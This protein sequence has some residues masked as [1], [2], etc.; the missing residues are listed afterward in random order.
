MIANGAHP[1][2]HLLQPRSRRQQRGER[3][4]EKVDEVRDADRGPAPTRRRRRRVLL[5]D[6]A[7]ELNRN[8]ANA[9]LKLLEEPPA[10]LLL[11]L[12]MPGPGATAARRSARAVPGSGCRRCRGRCVEA[13]ARARRTPGSPSRPAAVLAAAGRRQSAGR[14]VLEARLARQL[15]RPARERWRRRST[16]RR[17]ARGG[18]AS[19]RFGPEPGHRRAADLLAGSCAA[20][21]SRPPARHSPLSWSRARP[22]RSPV[23]AATQGLDRLIGLVGQAARAR[24]PRR[25][26]QSR[27]AAGLLPGSSGHRRSGPGPAPADALILSWR[28]W[29]AAPTPSTSRRR[30]T[31]STTRRISAT[32]T[33]RWPATCWPASCGSTAS[34]VV[35]HRHRRARPEGREGGRATR[36]RPAGLHRPGL[37]ALPRPR[38]AR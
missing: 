11:L 33:R 20:P 25:G 4:E 22:A 31:T 18:P 17:P 29:M 3:G 32:P 10:A 36:H 1:D 28:R 14:C 37:A 38:R 19:Q 16:A 7:D 35:P 6:A 13:G 30:S 8:A 34:D 23:L 2:L 5:V 9:L 24:R 27:P 21:R 12:V 26:A 15:C